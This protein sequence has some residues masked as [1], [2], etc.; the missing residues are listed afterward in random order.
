MLSLNKNSAFDYVIFY[1]KKK[2]LVLRSEI[3]RK[4]AVYRPFMPLSV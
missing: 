4:H 1:L 2:K 3:T